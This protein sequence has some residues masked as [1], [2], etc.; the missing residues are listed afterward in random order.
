MKVIDAHT[1]MPGLAANTVRGLAADEFL[2]GMAANGVDQAWFFT[3]DGLYFDPVPHN[4][5]LLQF[6][7]TDRARLIPFCTV[8]PRYPDPIG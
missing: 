7:A 8:R 3:L 2:Q 1:H 5:H 6:C 4:D